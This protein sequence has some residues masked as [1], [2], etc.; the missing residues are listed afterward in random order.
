MLT[1]LKWRLAVNFVKLLNITE[2]DEQQGQSGGTT[3]SQRY[4]I[5]E[6]SELLSMRGLKLLHQNIRGLLANKESV[7]QIL[8]DFKN[9]HLFPLS[10]THL[11]AN[12]E[13]QAQIDGFT[14]IGKPRSSGR[15]GGG[16]LPLCLTTEDVI[17]NKMI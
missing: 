10:E 9:V 8:L 14:F 17:S 4:D 6:L 5:P 1:R 3:G 13:A 15:G 12:E 2:N 11:H 16:V 7:N